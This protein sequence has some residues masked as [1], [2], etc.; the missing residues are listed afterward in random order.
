MQ[1]LVHFVFC[2]KSQ[3][4]N[5]SVVFCLKPFDS[6]DSYVTTSPETG[7]NQRPMTQYIVPYLKY[8]NIYRNML[9]CNLC[10]VMDS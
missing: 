5:G 10:I 6:L 9:I 3:Q 2:L 1:D 8:R 7:R 4:L